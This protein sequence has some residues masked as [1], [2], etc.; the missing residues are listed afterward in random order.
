[1]MVM[2]RVCMYVHVANFLVTMF[3]FR[4]QLQRR[5]TDSVF[6]QLLANFVFYFVGIAVC[7]DM[8]RRVMM[9]PVHTPN[10]DVMYPKHAVD[11]QNMFFKLLHV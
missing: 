6:F 9:M 3:T 10:V 4:F 1:M 7:Y 11:M 8:H 2:S 5:M